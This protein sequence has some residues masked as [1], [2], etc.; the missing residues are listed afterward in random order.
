MSLPSTTM[1]NLVG[2]D[3]ANERSGALFWSRKIRATRA[4]SLEGII[5]R[6]A[7]HLGG[8]VVPIATLTHSEY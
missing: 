2:S 6:S 7:G 8:S 5:P 3:Q 4:S 1:S